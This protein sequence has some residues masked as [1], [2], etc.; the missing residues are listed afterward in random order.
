MPCASFVRANVVRH[1]IRPFENR[2][3]IK[4]Y[5]S[6]REGAVS[7]LQN[8]GQTPCARLARHGASVHPLE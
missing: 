7:D 2:P 8:Q 3:A 4:P 6:W 1:V 5:C